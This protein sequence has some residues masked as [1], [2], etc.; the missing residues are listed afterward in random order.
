MQIFN[1][2]SLTY[3]HYVS[4][5]LKLFKKKKKHMNMPGFKLQR[6]FFRLLVQSVAM[7]NF[8]HHQIAYTIGTYMNRTASYQH[9]KS[10]VVT[11]VI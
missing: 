5:Q 8:A 11:Y 6:H 1:V 4:I 10:N 7:Y 3:T 9:Y 2:A